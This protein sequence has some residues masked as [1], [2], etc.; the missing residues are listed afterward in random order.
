[1]S[2]YK[3]GDKFWFE[4]MDVIY[5]GGGKTMYE[6]DNGVFAT[7]GML[8]DFNIVVQCKDC[9]H[10]PIVREDGIDT[11]RM[12]VGGIEA[13]GSITEREDFT[14]PCLCTGDEWYNENPP[15][16]F[17]CKDGEQ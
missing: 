4:I 7:D 3:K 15:D 2:K 12:T 9:R 5:D 17:F 13:D 1:M 8:D 6:C 11:P 16:D 10:R 14:C